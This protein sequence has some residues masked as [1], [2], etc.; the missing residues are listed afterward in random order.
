MDHHLGNKRKTIDGVL[1]NKENN[2]LVYMYLGFLVPRSTVA[3]A[4]H[5]TFHV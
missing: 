3:V 1:L 5:V 4:I 2:I